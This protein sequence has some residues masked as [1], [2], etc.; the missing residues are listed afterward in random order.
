MSE[1]SRRDF[2]RAAGLVAGAAAVPGAV[3][4][5]TSAPTS[6][7]K[8]LL[9]F[10]GYNFPRLQSL[11]NGRVPIEGCEVEFVPGKIGDMNTDL[12]SGDQVRDVTEVGFHPFILAYANGGFRDYSLLP[13]FPLRQFRQK[14]AFIRTDRGIEKPE[15]LK[16]KKISVAGYS[17]TSLTWLRG[18]MQDD[19]GVKP[20]DVTWVI[21]SGDSSAQ[22]AG[23]ISAQESVTPKGVPS[24]VGPV[25]LDESDLLEQGLVDACFHAAE[26]RAYV[27]GKPNIGR[28]FPNARPVEQE[29]YQ[30]TGVFPIM[31]TV[32]IRNELLEREPW[33]AKAVFNAYSKAKQLDYEFMTK[34]GWA[35][36]SLP[37][38]A[39]E[40]EDTRA[41]MG[42]NFYSYGF[43]ANK[44][45]IETLL[46]YSYDQK[47]ASRQLSAEELFAP[48]SLGF[49]EA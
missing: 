43:E 33:V 47:L 17:S 14:S 32:A 25:G 9:K 37:W 36:S 26:P 15:D 1:L 3:L 2:V 29:Y 41:L 31:H 45:A 8:L 23:K 46:T 39:Q 24:E 49:S 30:R 7:K 40:L 19:Y 35:F 10:G 44:K 4:A 22:V 13:V 38:F 34:M 6:S 27:Q 42:K 18:I 20:E 21:A 11:I 48:T 12:F 5:S 28:L 16:G